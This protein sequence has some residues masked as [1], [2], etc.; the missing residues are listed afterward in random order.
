[1]E[2]DRDMLRSNSAF[3]AFSEHYNKLVIGGVELLDYSGPALG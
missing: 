2:I 3:G 1:M